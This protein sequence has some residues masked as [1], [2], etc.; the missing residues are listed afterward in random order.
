MKLFSNLILLFSLCEIISSAYY[1]SCAKATSSS[2]TKADDCSVDSITPSDKSDDYVHCCFVE[3]KKGDRKEC[4][5][6]TSY[7]YENIGKFK[8]IKEEDYEYDYKIDCNS[9]YLQI[10]LI[11]I[12]SFILF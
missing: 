9:S 1:H 2:V 6:L 4:W 3:H 5:A 7:Q 12:L 10:C 8:K 11:M